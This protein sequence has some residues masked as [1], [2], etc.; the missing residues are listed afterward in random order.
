MRTSDIATHSEVKNRRKK[1]IVKSGV[2]DTTEFDSRILDRG[3]IV[4]G[5]IPHFHIAKH[6]ALETVV[7]GRGAA[8]WRPQWPPIPLTL[9]ARRHFHYIH[10]L[11]RTSLHPLAKY[12]TALDS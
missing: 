12:P 9:R 8:R 1:H 5:T 11:Y 3:E 6:L 2:V 10:A 7:G 4:R